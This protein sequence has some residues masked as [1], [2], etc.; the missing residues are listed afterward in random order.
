MTQFLSFS[1]PPPKDRVHYMLIKLTSFL[2]SAPLLI[3]CGYLAITDAAFLYNIH[4][5]EEKE[6]TENPAIKLKFT[7]Y[8][9]STFKLYK[10]RWFPTV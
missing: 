1:P 7:Y 6:T 8:Q 3:L 9:I 10:E 5:E 2:A 4:T